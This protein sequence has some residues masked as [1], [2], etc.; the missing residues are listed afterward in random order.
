[1]S[2]APSQNKSL[3][4]RIGIDL[5]GTKIAGIAL[6]PGADAPIWQARIAT[7]AG[8]YAATVRAIAD[9]VAAAERT[10][11]E[12]HL[13]VGVGIPGAVSPATGRIKNANSTC[14]IGHDLAGDLEQALGRPVPIANDA[15]CFALSEATDGAG[16]GAAVV[17][18]VILGTGVGSGIVVNGRPLTGANAIAG[19]IGHNPLPAPTE[20]ER[21]DRRCYCGRS[22]CAETFLSG[23][24]IEGEYQRLSGRR[25]RASEIAAAAGDRVASALMERTHDRLARM[26]AGAINTLDPDVIVL[27]GGLST[28]R[29]L[30][31]QVPKHWGAY[32]FSD[33]VATQLLPP[34]HGDASGVRG[35]ARLPD[36]IGTGPDGHALSRLFRFERA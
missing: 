34:V 15:N 30:Y 21:I 12:A 29:S 14:L 25:A 20:D 1:M 16:A 7:P 2:I 6:A 18:G 35:A 31:E 17:L 5:G 28:I 27:G 10:L 36:A 33:H 3:A 8:D 13:P 19:E 4:P 32:I 9:L 11:G 22:G 24:A 26:L 23:P